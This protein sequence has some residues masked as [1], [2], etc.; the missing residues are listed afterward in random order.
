[1]LCADN[2]EAQIRGFELC[3]NSAHHVAAIRGLCCAALGCPLNHAFD[4]FWTF[5]DLRVRPNVRFAPRAIL[6]AKSAASQG[7]QIVGKCCRGD[8]R[9]A[10]DVTR[11]SVESGKLREGVPPASIEGPGG[12]GT[13]SWKAVSRGGVA[14]VMRYS[15]EGLLR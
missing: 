10:L 7:R 15:G 11:T 2:Q 4:G 12:G 9:F 8:Q 5:R 6:P 14:A 13:P 1:M 3:S